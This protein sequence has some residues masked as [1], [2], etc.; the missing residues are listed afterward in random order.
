MLETLGQYKILDRVG[1]GRM[2]ELYRARDTRLGR[3]VAIRVLAA[4]LV[5]DPERRERVLGCARAAAALSHP[6]IAAL[7]EIGEDAG[8]LFLVHEFTA[9]EPLR[10]IIGG[11]PLNPRRAIDLGSQIADAL[12]DAH[13]EDLACGA[14]TAGN[15]V[16][17]PKGHAK[18][19]DFGLAG[20]TTGAS[21]EQAGGEPGD[22][23]HDIVSL[24]ALL[25]EM[26]TGKPFSGTAHG[27]VPD[28]LG[29]IVMK[30]LGIGGDG[31][32]ES[33]ATLAAELRAVAAVLDVRAAA[34]A[35]AAVAAVVRHAPGSSFGW[36]WLALLAGA[37]VAAVWYLRS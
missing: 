3:T 27:V 26:L 32:Y 31:R 25:F 23:R 36:I 29:P 16:V 22:H 33:A 9:G 1:A 2:G 20:A 10:R 35:P 28:E 19:L 6:N 18:V 11:Q 5:S 17:T 13:A 15:I 24:G 8:R 30:A 4:D 12:A 14:L 21:G 37:I 34:A 7:Y